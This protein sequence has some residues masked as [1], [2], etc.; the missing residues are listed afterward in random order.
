VQ[1][2]RAIGGS[3]NP[4]LPALYRD[5]EVVAANP[6]MGTLLS[7]FE[8]SVARP[9]AVTGLKYPSVSLALTNAA[10]DVL[11]HKTTPE[12]AVRRLEGK[13]KLVRRER[14]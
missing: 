7:T 3:F 8:E 10:H 1:K 13:L 9:S 2:Q 6:F 5:A 11:A 4:T 14:W 12:A